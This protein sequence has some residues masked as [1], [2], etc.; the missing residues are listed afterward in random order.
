M[1]ACPLACA[2]QAC[3]C[4]QALAALL[5]PAPDY[6]APADRR[7]AR[8]ETVVAFALEVGRLK[9][10]FHNSL[11]ELTARVPVRAGFAAQEAGLHSFSRRGITRDSANKKSVA[12][13]GMG[14]Q[15]CCPKE[16]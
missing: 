3:L 7:H 8:Q 12:F 5:P 1:L 9:S 14:F 10:P 4:R 2:R 13:P 6:I 15:H 16:L 11:L